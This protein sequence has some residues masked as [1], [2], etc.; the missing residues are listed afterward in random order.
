[1]RCRGLIFTTKAT[2]AKAIKT[3]ALGGSLLRGGRD[4]TPAAIA[5]GR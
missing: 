3:S 4:A 1:M 5:S 2:A